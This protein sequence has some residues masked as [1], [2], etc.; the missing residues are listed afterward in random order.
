MSQNG[1]GYN[2]DDDDDDDDNDT[3][4]PTEQP[5]LISDAAQQQTAARREQARRSMEKHQLRDAFCVERLGVVL[6]GV[7]V[8]V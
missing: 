8:C 3:P 1:Y 4:R 5:R 6:L 7:C 2:N